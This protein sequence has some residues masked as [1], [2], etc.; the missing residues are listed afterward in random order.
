MGSKINKTD[1]RI[2]LIMTA[3]YLVIALFYLGDLKAPQT[4]WEPERLND[5]FIIDFGREVYIDKIMLYGGLGHAWGC[6]GSLEI[7]AHRNGEFIP[8]TFVD[9]KSVFKWHYSTDTIKTDKL[10]ITAINLRS[11]REEDK[12][13]YYKAEYREMGFFSGDDLITGF[14]VEKE[15]DSEGIERLFDEQHL[16]PERPT[17]LNGTYFDEVYFPRTAFEQL[18]KRNILYE[19]THPPL[20]KTIL[21]LGIRVFGMT[22]FGWRIMGTLFGAALIPLMYLIAKRF[23]KDTFWA[24]FCAFIMMFDFM[25]FAQ[26]RLATIDSY[27]VFFVMLMYYFMLEYYDSRSYEKGLFK[28]MI[29]LLLCGISLGLGAATKWIALYGAFGLAVLFFMSRGY[30]FSGYNNHLNIVLK[31][32]RNFSQKSKK[33]GGWL[34]KYFYLTCLFCV[35]FFI[36]IPMVIYALSFIPISYNEGD[37]SLIKIVID[38]VKSMYEYHKGVDAV[39]PY[40]SPWYEW[41]LNIRPIFYYQGQLLDPFWGASVACFGHPLLF[42]FGLISFIVII[43]FLIVNMFRKR[44]YIGDNKLLFFPVIGYLSQYLPWVVAPRKITFIYHYFSCVPFL[45][46]MLG[47]VFRYLEER[48]IFSRTATKVFLIVFLA[49]FVI[50]YPLLSGIVVPRFYLNGLQLLPRWEW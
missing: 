40:S 37:K 2:M 6:F 29:P 43:Y 31:E 12:N 49:L 1:I 41:P 23:F 13:R 27:T 19:N 36:I 15:P 38:S 30:E 39:H 47:I 18:D 26:T 11:D 50:Y 25:H 10:R 45:I 4:G 42:W 17:I 33:L 28:S 24:F 44:K 5:S 7:E 8:Y 35:I 14:K 48:G 21:S 20:G 3:I 22:P 9:M 16:V 46:L 32:H 34:G